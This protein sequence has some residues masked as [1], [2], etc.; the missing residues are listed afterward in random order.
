M[1]SLFA[2][3]CLNTPL[4]VEHAHASDV[5]SSI[6]QAENFLRRGWI[7]DAI[8][9]LLL[10]IGTDEGEL[11]FEAH[12]ILARVL[13]ETRDA[14]AALHYART[15]ERLAMSPTEAAEM[16]QLADYIDSAFGIVTVN[17]PYPGMTS[18]LQL[19]S[20]TPIL[21]PELREFIDEVALKW[22]NSTLL[23]ARIAL[24]NGGYLINGHE[25]RVMADNEMQVDLP[26]GSIGSAGFAALQ[27]SRVELSTG[28]SVLLSDRGRNLRPSFE[29]QLAV[30]QPIGRWLVGATIDWSMRGFS[31]AG[32]NTSSAPYAIN[33]GIRLGREVMIGGPLAVQPSFGYRLGSLPGIELAC[34][35]VTDDELAGPY[36]CREPDANEPA[37]VHV[38]EIATTHAI[39]SELSVS[40]RRAGRTTAS[41]V[42][43]KLIGEYFFGGIPESGEATFTKSDDEIE[44]SLSDPEI[45]SGVS[46]F[47]LRMLASFSYAF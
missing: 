14:E 23:P 5:E 29:M 20:I 17:P 47:N 33:S 40:Y 43:I 7:D 39:Y 24:P 44:Y 21:D 1:I 34:T 38:Y 30:T 11:S 18:F 9:E 45:D 19:E 12:S 31:V 41:G 6:S 35:A 36:S 2:A 13:Y 3:L 10:A 15:A 42:G 22:S 26:M 27:V 16:S 25:V 46:G 8:E 28:T 32:T 4:F 37:E